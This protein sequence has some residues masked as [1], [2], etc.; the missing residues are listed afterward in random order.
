MR[1]KTKASRENL[2]KMLLFVEQVCQQHQ[3]P[4]QTGLN[5]QLVVEEACVNII[6][7]GYAD[8][9]PG[10]IAITFE[11]K[12]HQVFITITDFGHEFDPTKYPPPDL[13]SE[14][15]QR[16]VGGLGVYLIT[17]LMDGV[18]YTSDPV[19]GNRLEL[20]KNIEQDS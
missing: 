4:R 9:P 15:D 10:T 16:P 20:T 14:W 6:E 2:S 18:R 13:S 7:H 5:L 17:K 8:L 3:I 12:D 19:H 11:I 1:I